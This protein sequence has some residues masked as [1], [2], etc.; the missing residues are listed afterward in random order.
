[1][2]EFGLAFVRSG[3]KP[4][5]VWAGTPSNSGHCPDGRKPVKAKHSCQ[6]PDLLAAR[7]YAAHRRFS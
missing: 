6:M 4:G 1:V 5:S 3:S 2:R 7:C